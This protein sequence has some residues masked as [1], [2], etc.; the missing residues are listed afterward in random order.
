MISPNSYREEHKNLSL[1]E[2]IDKRNE[3]IKSLNNYENNNIKNENGNNLEVVMS[4]SPA[5]RYHWYNEYLKEIT[6]LMIKYAQNKNKDGRLYSVSF[7]ANVIKEAPVLILILKSKDDEWDRY[8]ALSV[9]A[10]IENMCLRSTELNLG[11]LWIGDT[12]FV[13]NEILDNTISNEVYSV[14][15]I[16]VLK[17]QKFDLILQKA[18]E[19]GVSEIIPYL[20]KRS[21]V[22]L[23]K[24]DFSKKI[25]RWNK[26][27]KEASEQSKRVDI[28]I[29]NSIKDIDDLNCIDGVK[30][31]C[32]TVEK[33]KNIKI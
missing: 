9:G 2:L 31:M 18:T 13:E 5:T 26:I 33:S 14:I 10:A 20:S 27:L 1:I 17:E 8:D 29:L 25:I 4:P 32:S 16:P 15:I 3:L 7:T 22:K 24:D 30:L 28:P 23:D 6:D 21:V 19:L 11:T 12:D